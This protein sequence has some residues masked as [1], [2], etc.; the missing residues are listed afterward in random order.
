[1]NITPELYSDMSKNASPKSNTKVNVPIAFAVGEAI[2]V[3]G[4][5]LMKIF[6]HYGLEKTAAST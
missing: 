5:I 4:E 3:I 1:M 2:C 6:G